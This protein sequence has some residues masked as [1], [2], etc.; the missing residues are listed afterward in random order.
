MTLQSCSESDPTTASA[1][2]LIKQFA[3]KARAIRA[4][5]GHII[6]KALEIA[7][8]IPEGL[9]LYAFKNMQHEAL[10]QSPRFTM[11]LAALLLKCARS[12][13]HPAL[14]SHGFAI[15]PVI[16]KRWPHFYLAESAPDIH[17]VLSLREAA[18]RICPGDVPYSVFNGLM[19]LA[20]DDAKAAD[21]RAWAL[22]TLITFR[23]HLELSEMGT[24]FPL[25]VLEI[26]LP[27]SGLDYWMAEWA[28]AQLALYQKRRLVELIADE[29]NAP[30]DLIT[31]PRNA[32][33]FLVE[34]KATEDA[35]YY[36]RNIV[37]KSEQALQIVSHPQSTCA[38]RGLIDVEMFS[39]WLA[40]K[41]L[42]AP[43]R[44]LLIRRRSA[45][46]RQMRSRGIDRTQ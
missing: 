44:T 42:T 25:D 23:A 5:P 6:I 2:V 10:T 39:E 1:Q 26:A 36:L 17:A 21:D 20:V 19:A 22:R 3:T 4:I 15:C 8:P 9:A 38:Q 35:R 41:G 31:I 46:R 30:L 28:L 32:K 34:P 27:E 45:L 7:D 29:I 11:Q 37:S 16:Y 40:I 33:D 14:C 13:E 24:Q 43:T 12:Y 18:S